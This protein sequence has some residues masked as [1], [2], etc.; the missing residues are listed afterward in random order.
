MVP[1]QFLLNRLQTLLAG[2]TTTFNAPTAMKAHLAQAAFTPGPALTLASFTEATFTGYAAL[3]AGVGTGQTFNDV[4]GGRVV[5]ALEPAG[6]WHWQATGTTGLPQ[7][8]YGWYLS[9]NG[10]TQLYASGLFVTP[11]VLTQ[12]GDAVDVPQVRVTIA[13]TAMF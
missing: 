1:S 2:D 8:I 13:T 5:Q 4:T 11:I 3:A 9:D 6:G 10:N 12:T 7:T